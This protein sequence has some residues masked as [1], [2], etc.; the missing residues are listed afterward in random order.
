MKSKKKIFI[1]NINYII[2]DTKSINVGDNRYFQQVELLE[3][4]GLANYSQVEFSNEELIYKCAER[5]FLKTNKTI[6]SLIIASTSLE[7]SDQFN[8]LRKIDYF[9]N[10]YNIT[11]YPIGYSLSNCANLIGAI[12]IAISLIISEDINNILVVISDKVKSY[13]ERFMESSESFLSDGA[14]GFIVSCESGEYEINNLNQTIDTSYTMNEQYNISEYYYD[15][16]R[17]MK[18]AI[19]NMALMDNI[20]VENYSK[21]ILGNYNKMLQNMFQKIDGISED[22]LFF[23][24][25]SK[26]AHV[27]S[28]DLL[29]NLINSEEKKHLKIGEKCLLVGFGPHRCEV[30]SLKK[31][32]K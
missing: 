8:I 1:D 19:S 15:T 18:S 4:L 16:A 12:R 26:I 24:N 23:D 13:S 6:D 20:Q 14:V 2:G 11:V 3:T 17:L 5:T 28:S 22:Q 30:L 21:I 25:V 31:Q 7:Y 29:I 10:Q 32:E 27:F 9:L